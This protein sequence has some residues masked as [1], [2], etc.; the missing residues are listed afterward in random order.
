[1]IYTDLNKGRVDQARSSKKPDDVSG[2]EQQDFIDSD[3]EISDGDEDLF[4]DAIDVIVPEVK[5]KKKKKAK[6][7]QLKAIEIRVPTVVDDD[8]D[9][10]D[11]G[12]DLPESDGEGEERM[13]FNSWNQED[14]NNLAFSVGLVFPLVRECQTSNYRVVC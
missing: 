6:G 4:E 8:A 14:M 12:L 2:Y 13:R 7:S 9:I 5:G 3:Y 11:D 1:M 10:E